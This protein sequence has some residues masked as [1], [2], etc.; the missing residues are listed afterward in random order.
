VLLFTNKPATERPQTRHVTFK[1]Q[2]EYSTG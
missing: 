1:S 2:S